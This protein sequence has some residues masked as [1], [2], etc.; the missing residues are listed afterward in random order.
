MDG[1]SALAV[2]VETG[3]SICV[4]ADRVGNS[5]DAVV[6]AVVGVMSTKVM[7]GNGV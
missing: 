1:I 3:G 4:P 6:V 7:I 5:A 2:V